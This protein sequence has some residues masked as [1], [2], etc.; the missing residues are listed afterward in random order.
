[1]LV[2]Y[3]ILHMGYI[4]FVASTNQNAPNRSRDWFPRALLISWK[5]HPTSVTWQVTPDKRHTTVDNWHRTCW[6]NN[7]N[8]FIFTIELI[9]R[10]RYIC[11]IYAFIL[12]T[13]WLMDYIYHTWFPWHRHKVIWT[14]NLARPRR[15]NHCI[16]QFERI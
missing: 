10:T 9:I 5:W 16:F 2:F 4:K 8:I 12:V 7:Q 6:W 14:A 13:R 1:M 3:I 15:A 11:I